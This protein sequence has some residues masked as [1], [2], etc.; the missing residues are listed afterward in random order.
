MREASSPYPDSSFLVSLLIQDAHTAQAGR[1]MSNLNAPLCVTPL[2]RHEVRSAIHQAVFRGEM[3]KKDRQAVFLQF[4]DDM[5][6]GF[7]AHTTVPWTA[8]F[9]EASRLGELFVE[10]L[11]TRGV[12]VLHVSIA[13][14]LGKSTIVTFDKRQG[15]LAEKAGLQWI[16]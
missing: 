2:H 15:R 5:R 3:E 12:D 8:T 6:A 16:H 10:D 11:G 7:F 1:I 4:D 14:S 9:Q 13:I